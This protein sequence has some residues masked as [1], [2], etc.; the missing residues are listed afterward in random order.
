MAPKRRRESDESAAERAKKPRKDKDIPD[1]D[2]E[3]MYDAPPASEGLG[4]ADDTS[5]S[6]AAGGKA[7]DETE[8]R[9]IELGGL[10]YMDLPFDLVYNNN[11]WIHPSYSDKSAKPTVAVHQGPIP[12]PKPNPDPNPKPVTGGK[13]KKKFLGIKA[14]HGGW[15]GVEGKLGSG[16]QG[17][18]KDFSTVVCISIS[19]SHKKRANNN[20]TYQVRKTFLQS[21]RATKDHRARCHQRFLEQDTLGH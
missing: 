10:D 8:I 12:V 18:V 3:E 13:F 20:F 15:I 21:R 4:E 7:D 5:A 1:D 9:R 19:L 17:Y 6:G 2:D 14:L 11:G 16:G